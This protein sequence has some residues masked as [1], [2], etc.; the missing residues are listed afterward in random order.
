MSQIN[1]SFGSGGMI[2]ALN[3]AQFVQLLKDDAP[4]LP[5]RTEVGKQEVCV[6]GEDLQVNKSG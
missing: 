5:I 2:L 4:S 1:N 6:M 3:E